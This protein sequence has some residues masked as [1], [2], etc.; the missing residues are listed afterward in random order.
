MENSVARH[1]TVKVG[2]D[3]IVGLGWHGTSTTRK[4]EGHDTG[5][6]RKWHGHE[7]DVAHET[8]LVWHGH[9]MEV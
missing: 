1:D 6:K 7:M 4:C 3:I 2:N 5:T 8:M 9:D